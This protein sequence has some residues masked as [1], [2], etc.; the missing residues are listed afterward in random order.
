MVHFDV[1]SKIGCV[2]LGVFYLAMLA[3]I[4]MYVCKH[5]GGFFSGISQYIKPKTS[6]VGSAQADDLV[7]YEITLSK[8]K[9]MKDKMQDKKN[10]KIR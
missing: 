10:R 6:R 8:M 7:G 9:R 1:L 4:V 5:M 3:I 2:I